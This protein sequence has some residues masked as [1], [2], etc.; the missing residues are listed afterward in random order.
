LNHYFFFYSSS[1]LCQNII[2]F[3]II[4][5]LKSDLHN[6]TLHTN[7]NDAQRKSM[8]S[9]YSS[10]TVLPSGQMYVLSNAWEYVKHIITQ[11]YFTAVFLTVHALIL[12]YITHT[13]Q[14]FF[15]QPHVLLPPLSKVFFPQPHVLL[16]PLY[17]YNI[18]MRC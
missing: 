15:L 7:S 12:H 9:M 1:V 13:V 3:I 16:T 5:V 14:V 4:M 8:W 17:R 6:T 18:L 2:F 11:L 10:I